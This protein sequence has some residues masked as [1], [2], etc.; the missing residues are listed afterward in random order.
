MLYKRGARELLDNWREITLLSVVF[1]TFESVINSRLVAFLDSRSLLAETQ[2]GFRRGR[3]TED[4]PFILGEIL[5]TRRDSGLLT[6]LSF[7]DVKC[8]YDSVFRD[9]FYLNLQELG[10]RGAVWCM[11]KAM[12]D[13]AQRQV[14]FVDILS[15]VYELE[16]GF[17]QGGPGVPVAF[18]VYIN[19]MAEALARVESGVRLGGKHLGSQLFADDVETAAATAAQL[20]AQLRVGTEYAK[21]DG[22][23][24]NISKCAVA[25][26]GGSA[27][28]RA[29]VANER[30]ELGG[31]VMP[32]VDSYRYVGIDFDLNARGWNTMANRVLA[33]VA[34]VVAI[35]HGAGCVRAAL[36]PA[37]CQRLFV[38]MVR[39]QLEFGVVVWEPTKRQAERMEVVQ[40]RFARRALG[41]PRSCG[42]WMTISEFG[43]LP[44]ASRR[45]MMRMRFFAHAI[46]SASPMVNAVFQHT[47]EEVDSGRMK[48]SASA[49]IK[50]AMVRYGFEREWV[51]RSVPES[52]KAVV[53]ARVKQ[54]TMEERVVAASGSPS[55]TRYIRRNP[56]FAMPMANKARGY[57][58]GQWLK[59]RL[60]TDTLPLLEVIWRGA[61]AESKEEEAERV[62]CEGCGEGPEDE[63]HFL[64]C[65]GFRAMRSEMLDRCEK[66][67]SEAKVALRGSVMR[68]LRGPD[69]VVAHDLMLGATHVGGVVAGV[70]A[71][72]DDFDDRKLCKAGAGVLHKAVCVYLVLCWKKRAEWYQGVPY[73]ANDGSL[74]RDT[75]LWESL[76]CVRRDG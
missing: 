13:G 14:R 23:A 55:L 45:D 52:W 64:D 19:P 1:K 60:R 4:N 68:A 21:R 63:G 10:V 76:R 34:R 57:T 30:F 49:R 48:K 54:R 51:T 70:G 6:L 22:L 50:A 47:A 31:E 27:M 18:N 65:A 3:R 12:Y 42:N 35:L 9:R 44:L 53:S 73:R 58:R 36:T 69:R 11:Y 37:V 61:P 32:L 74:K 39:S 40:R 24:F 56:E 5:A 29:S 20:H 7:W 71:S 26:V 62:R 38:T 46:S 17:T 2:G 75:D 25:V 16:R 67:L 72:A 43:V 15:E 66:A 33:K 28:Q 59:R 41:L 8:A